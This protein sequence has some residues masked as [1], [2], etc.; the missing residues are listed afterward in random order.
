[1]YIIVNQCIICMSFFSIEK[2][3]EKNFVKVLFLLEEWLLL[4]S[5]V[6]VIES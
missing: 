5:L 3:S 1:M 4:P 6:F 2:S